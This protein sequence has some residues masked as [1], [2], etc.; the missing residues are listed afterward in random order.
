MTEQQAIDEMCDLWTDIEH[1]NTDHETL[2]SEKREMAFS[3]AE[4]ALEMQMPEKII[5]N[6]EKDREYEDYICPNCKD[7]LQ[8]RRKGATADMIYKFKFCHRCGQRLD[9]E[10][11]DYADNLKHLQR[12]G[13]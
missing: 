10:D 5:F 9:W 12:N 4:S 13:G 1:H 3:M 11:G 6:S 2:W 8:Q 7:I